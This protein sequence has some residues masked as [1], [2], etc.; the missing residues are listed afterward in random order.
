MTRSTL[1]LNRPAAPAR[2]SRTGGLCFLTTPHHTRTYRASRVPACVQRKHGRCSHPAR[3]AARE[4]W[5]G[6]GKPW[7]RDSMRPAPSGRARV[8]AGG[9]TLVSGE[10]E[11]AK[12]GGDVEAR[13]SGGRP[14]FEQG[15]V[16]RP[17]RTTRPL[18]PIGVEAPAV[19]RLRRERD[20]RRH[21][22]GAKPAPWELGCRRPPDSAGLVAERADCGREPHVI[23]GELRHEIRVRACARGRRR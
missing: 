4:S 23:P 22:Q 1:F 15:P 5:S 20:V 9:R 14:G 11:R 12:R 3:V 17:L 8:N 16:L 19:S 2:E 6:H 18:D 21:G 7:K 13:G 10:A